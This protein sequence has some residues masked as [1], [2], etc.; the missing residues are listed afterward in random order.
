MNRAAKGLDAD[1]RDLL[2]ELVDANAM[3]Q[4]QGR[5]IALLRKNIKSH[6]GLEQTIEEVTE[7]R[8]RARKQEQESMD[9][10]HA[11]SVESERQINELKEQLAASQGRKCIGGSSP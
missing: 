3:I 8:E 6:K 2:K 9:L 1:G 4:K 11:I 7:Q 10:I 5:R